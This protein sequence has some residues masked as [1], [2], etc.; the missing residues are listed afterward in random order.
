MASYGDM[1]DAYNSI[2]GD[3]DKIAVQ[4]AL[5]TLLTC[6]IIDEETHTE[7]MEKEVVKNPYPSPRR[8]HTPPTKDQ[9]AQRKAGWKKLGDRKYYDSPRD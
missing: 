7:L 9:M 6:G 8:S 2:Y 5:D 3:R 1:R 4:E